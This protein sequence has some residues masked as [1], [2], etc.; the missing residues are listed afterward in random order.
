MYNTVHRRSRPARAVSHS[1]SRVAPGHD[2][3]A[4]GPHTAGSFG[5]KGLRNR[6]GRRSQGTTTVYTQ[7]LN[8][9]DRR[10]TRSG[11]Q[12]TRGCDRPL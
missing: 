11:S 6:V 8:Y 2:R 12:P 5:L 1:I 10:P 9:R 4:T 7:S 3:K